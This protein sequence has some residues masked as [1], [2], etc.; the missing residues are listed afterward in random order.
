MWI[1]PRSSPRWMR[2]LIDAMSSRRDRLVAK[3]ADA[4]RGADKPAAPKCPFCRMHV[5][6]RCK[7]A[8]EASRCMFL[9]RP[10]QGIARPEAQTID[11]PGAAALN[12]GESAVL[13]INPERHPV[14]AFLLM[15]MRRADGSS[16]NVDT[17]YPAYLAWHGGGAGTGEPLSAQSFGESLAYIF[18]RAGIKTRRDGDVVLCLDVRLI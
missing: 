7:G 18:R 17:L 6:D 10:R 2:P 8:D 12:G 16:L 13:G 14:V 5:P 1:D 4:V 15:R 9:P 3:A 11:L